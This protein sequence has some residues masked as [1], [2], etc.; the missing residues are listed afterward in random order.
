MPLC[1]LVVSSVH[2]RPLESWSSPDTLL[3]WGRRSEIGGREHANDICRS[4]HL[5][6]VLRDVRHDALG[7]PRTT[8]C[9]QGAV[10]R[11]QAQ[12]PTLRLQGDR[13]GLGER[14]LRVWKRCIEAILGTHLSHGRGTHV[15]RAREREVLELLLRGYGADTSAERLDIS[16]ETVRR[17][18]K[19]IYKKLDVSCQADLFALFI[20]SMPYIGEAQGNDPLS[21]YM[22]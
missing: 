10:S 7:F 9:R 20:N 12:H 11:R 4:G 6:G 21:V 3:C 18:R 1:V 19:S 5:F 2:A 15:G 14:A 17:H 13:V 16:L 8:R 22:N